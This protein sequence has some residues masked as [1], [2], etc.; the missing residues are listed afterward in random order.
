MARSEKLVMLGGQD[1]GLVGLVK[2]P[3]RTA[4]LI[5]APERAEPPAGLAGPP[6]VPSVP[7]PAE[8]AASPP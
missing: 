1:P 2:A 4:H 6:L 3:L 8:S 7:T 5:V